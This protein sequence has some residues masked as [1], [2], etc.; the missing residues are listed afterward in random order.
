MNIAIAN[1]LVELRSAKGWTQ[2]ELAE[3]L[4]VSRQ[5]VSKWERAESS[6]ELDKLVALS[7]LYGI[8]LDSLLDTGFRPEGSGSCAQGK[9]GGSAEEREAGDPSGAYPASP[10]PPWQASG[11]AVAA[12]SA[13]GREE[14]EILEA[15]AADDAPEFLDA[16]R[17]SA[18]WVLG[19]F[20]YPIA[21][22][23]VYLLLGFTGGWWHPGWLLFLTVPLYYLMGAGIDCARSAGS[24]WGRIHAFLLGSGFFPVLVSAL[25]I[26]MGVLWGWWHPGWCIFLLIPLLYCLPEPR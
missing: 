11:V 9:N 2:E 13:G 22:A 19:R 10:A 6:P 25:Y 15:L 21:V 24:T 16:G 20:P 26:S 7:R 5:A 18:E 23:L 14:Q 8:S 4:D 3:K 12:L 17:R 1:R